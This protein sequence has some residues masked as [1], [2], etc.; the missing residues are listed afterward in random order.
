MFDPR[1]RILGFH[2]KAG[3]NFLDLSTHE[4]IYKQ[5]GWLRFFFPKGEAFV[6]DG[7]MTRLDRDRRRAEVTPEIGGSGPGGFFSADETLLATFDRPSGR[8]FKL[9]SW[10]P[11][12]LKTEL[13]GHE[14][15]V[16][17]AAFSHDKRTLA[18]GDESGVVKLW[19][20]ATGKDL[21]ALE[22]HT[23]RV[24]Q[25]QFSPDDKTVAVCSGAAKPGGTATIA[26][27]QTAEDVSARRH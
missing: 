5:T 13:K 7:S 11:P 24:A 22:Q 8:S 9:W 18:S 27:W 20:V 10:N 1:G 23:S 3:S 25:I 15:I 12:K 26:L 4:V 2:T 17:A 14:A 21:V 19:N 16:S 6:D